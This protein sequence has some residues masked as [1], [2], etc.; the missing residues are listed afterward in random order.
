MN[1]AISAELDFASI[2]FKVR[3]KPTNLLLARPKLG[4]KR[5]ARVQSWLRCMRIPQTQFVVMDTLSGC[6]FGSRKTR[7]RPTINNSF[8]REKAVS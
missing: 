5:K 4:N 2:K 1:E 7:T 3:I 8:Y 6:P